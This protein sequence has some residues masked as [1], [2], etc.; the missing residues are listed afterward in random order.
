MTLEYESRVEVLAGTA[1]CVLSLAEYQRRTKI[2]ILY[3]FIWAV[4]KR[5][6]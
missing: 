4:E 3:N 1:M 5:G 2:F 6:M